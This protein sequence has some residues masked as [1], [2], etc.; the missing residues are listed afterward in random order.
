M[1]LFAAALLLAGAEEARTADCAF[2]VVDA[3]DLPDLAGLDRPVLVRNAWGDAW[4]P[5]RGALPAFRAAFDAVA[6]RT[7]EDVRLQ[8]ETGIIPASAAGRL[9]PRA[10]RAGPPD[11]VRFN[12]RQ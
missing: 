4:D 12:P 1:G 7:T 6:L 3:A 10:E 5:A 8:A 2:D 9:E 11:R